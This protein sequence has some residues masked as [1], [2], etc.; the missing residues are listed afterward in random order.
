MQNISRYGKV[1]YIL[2]PR[3]LNWRLVWGSFANNGHLLA[4]VWYFIAFYVGNL[5]S[6]NKLNTR[7]WSK[8]RQ[9][10]SRMFVYIYVRSLKNH[11]Q[12]QQFLLS[13]SKI[14]TACWSNIRFWIQSLELPAI[15]LHRKS[16]KSSWVSWSFRAFTWLPHNRDMILLEVLNRRT[17]SAM[18]PTLFDTKIFSMAHGFVC[19]NVK[20]RLYY[21][22]DPNL[23]VD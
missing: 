3:R 23:C 2:W 22:Y 12:K 16:V 21:N 14:N 5:S 15:H 13:L 1:S 17:T 18:V 10:N 7:D 11:T 9:A 20:R 4:A 8:W 6:I 19:Q